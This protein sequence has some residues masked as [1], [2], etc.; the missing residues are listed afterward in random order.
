[1]TGTHP[2][3]WDFRP[4]KVTHETYEDGSVVPHL[5]VSAWRDGK[6][7]GYVE[8]HTHRT[9]DGHTSFGVTCATLDPVD[10]VTP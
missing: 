3:T 8:I 9:K 10:A 7:I 1:M 2:H 4:G 6:K 5:T